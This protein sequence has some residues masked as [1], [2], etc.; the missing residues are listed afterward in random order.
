MTPTS[1]ILAAPLLIFA[2]LLGISKPSQAALPKKLRLPGHHAPG[3]AK[4]SCPDFVVELAEKWGRVFEV[5]REWICSQAF[6]E[7][8]NDPSRV[9]HKSGAVGLLQV[10]PLTA[11]WHI[12]NL[13]RF[14]SDLVKK[15]IARLWRGRAS[16]LLN[17][18]LNVLVAAAHMKFLKNIFGD[19]HDLVAA[20]YDAGHNKILRLLKQGKPLPAESQLYVAMVHEAKQR[21]Y[22]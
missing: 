21:G 22:V 10:L 9:N 5:P 18:D 8:S 3:S 17:P 15:T 20:A 11:V 19:D 16:D 6:V 1:L 7:S 13:K 12:E 2:L 14:G 4:E